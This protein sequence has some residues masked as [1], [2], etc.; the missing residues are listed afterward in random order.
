MPVTLAMIRAATRRI[1]DGVVVT[2]CL[3]SIPLSELT[4][5]RVFCKL[6]NE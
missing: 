5:A 6:D 2:P 1:A 3:E 4:G